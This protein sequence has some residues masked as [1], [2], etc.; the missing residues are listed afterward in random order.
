MRPSKFWRRYGFSRLCYV[1][2]PCSGRTPSVAIS[3]IKNPKTATLSEER[4][5][6]LL[7]MVD[8]R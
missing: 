2:P 8:E 6:E 4:S 5:E 3:R 7:E 1:F